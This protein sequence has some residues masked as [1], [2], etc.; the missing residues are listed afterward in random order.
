MLLDAGNGEAIPF[1]GGGVRGLLGGDTKGCLKVT[2]G[3]PGAFALGIEPMEPGAFDLLCLGDLVLSRGSS[4]DVSDNSESMLG[5][6]GSIHDSFPRLSSC[7]TGATGSKL[8]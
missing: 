5:S 7:A 4:S 8:A 6:S 1:F 2:D 3:E